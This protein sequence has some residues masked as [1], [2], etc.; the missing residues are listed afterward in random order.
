MLNTIMEIHRK[1][2]KTMENH[3]EQLYLVGGDWNHGMDHD[4]PF[5]WEIHGEIHR[6]MGKTMENHDE[7]LYLVGGLE[8]E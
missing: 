3:D 1:L 7:Q 4:F 5:S 2:G 8:H 6:K